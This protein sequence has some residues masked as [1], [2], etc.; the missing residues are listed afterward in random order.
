MMLILANIFILS[1]IIYAVTDNC[2][3][4]IFKST[5]IF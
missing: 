4:D 1:V 2:I 5:F 3:Q